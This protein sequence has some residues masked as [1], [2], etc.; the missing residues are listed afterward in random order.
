[1]N[2]K[3]LK[4][5]SDLVEIA[6]QLPETTVLIPGGDR[7]DDIRLVDAACDYGILSKAIFV[8]N[9]KRIIEHASHL[10]IDIEKHTI[11]GVDDEQEI[12]QKTVDLVDSGEVD[13]VL[14]GGISTPVIN[15]AMLKLAVKPTVSLASIF[16]ASPIS[17]GR[18][19]IL[20]D[21][22]VTTDCNFDRMVDIIKNAVEVAQTVMGIARPKVAV[23]SANEKQI[24]SLPSTS[25][26][27]ELAK[28]AWDNALVCGPLSFDLATD[29]DSVSTKGIPDCP[30]AKEVA[31][32]ADILVCPCIDSANILYKTIA[33]MIKYGDASIAGITVGFKVPYI[34]LSRS[35]SLFTRLESVALCS[36]YAHRQQ[37][38]KGKSQPRDNDSKIK[39]PGLPMTEKTK[40]SY[41]VFQI[42]TFDCA[43]AL[44]S[45]AAAF[46]NEGV[47]IHAV[48][49]YGVRSD[50]KGMIEVGFEGDET[51]KE[52][53]I[54]RIKRL[55]KVINV[56]EEKTTPKKPP[57]LISA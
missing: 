55:T 18:P 50:Q 13:I 15:R 24:S 8:G 51:V 22:G 28:L 11:I 31:G 27:L 47:S 52:I 49:G 40:K 19:M 48:T 26:G 20:T 5:V 42:S 12:G 29:P 14:K 45:V 4:S 35:D 25:M 16:D 36:I 44:T 46:S 9:E 41:W 17:D 53:L 32:K 10:C 54:R 1:M 33:S 43:G 39:Y 23:L 37:G 56:R 2:D 3:S 38:Y 57:Q 34:I 6:G 21:A 7:I 30:H